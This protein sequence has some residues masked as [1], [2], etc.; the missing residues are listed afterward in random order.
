MPLYSINSYVG[1]FFNEGPTTN[2]VPV[3]LRVQCSVVMLL[4]SGRLLARRGP[5]GGVLVP[6]VDG[7]RGPPG[8]W[9]DASRV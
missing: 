4:T 7:A 2:A 9:V 6:R 3:T 1:L 8:E 5:G